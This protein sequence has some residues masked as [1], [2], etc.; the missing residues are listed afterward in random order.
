[1]TAATSSTARSNAS[2]FAWDGFCIPLTLRTYWTAAASIS[3]CVVGGS[4][5]WRVRMLRQ[6]ALLSYPDSGV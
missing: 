1:V 6:M 4:K 3:S 5:L 2:A